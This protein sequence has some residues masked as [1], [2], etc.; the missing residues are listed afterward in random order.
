MVESLRI[1]APD[2]LARPPVKGY[3][4]CIQTS[5]QHS[6]LAARHHS[7]AQYP[8]NGWDDEPKECSSPGRGALS[9]ICHQSICESSVTTRSQADSYPTR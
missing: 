1:M 4:Y 7:R 3:E 9:E 8:D 6:R 2:W 5:Y